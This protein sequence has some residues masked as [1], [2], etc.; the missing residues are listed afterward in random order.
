MYVPQ[1][2]TTTHDIAVKLIH[3]AA[4]KTCDF[5]VRLCI[6]IE[7]CT[8]VLI[9]YTIYKYW[10]Y[11]ILYEESDPITSWLCYLFFL[12]I[13]IA[14]FITEALCEYQIPF[15]MNTCLMFTSRTF[16]RTVL[17]RLINLYGIFFLF[18]ISYK[19]R[20]SIQIGQIFF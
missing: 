17:I 2:E 20:K 16:Q 7:L 10:N 14:S 8:A 6:F 9:F 13:C 4:Y 19:Q 1:D 15:I 18:F 12:S 3:L 11:K 5:I